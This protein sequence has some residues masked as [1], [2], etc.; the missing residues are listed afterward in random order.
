MNGKG[1]PGGRG[2]VGEV[3]GTPCFQDIHGGET[4]LLHGM[5][6]NGHS[7]ALQSVCT[8]IPPGEPL[9]FPTVMNICMGLLRASPQLLG[10]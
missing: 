8:F 5:T 9:K 7:Q 4:A 1:D 6:V 10:L 2:P 3:M